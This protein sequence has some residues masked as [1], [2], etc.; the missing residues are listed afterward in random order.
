MD[1]KRRKV[2]LSSARAHFNSALPKRIADRFQPNGFRKALAG[3][4]KSH[5]G[6]TAFPYHPFWT[7]N[8]MLD[9]FGVGIGLY[10]RSLKAII[11]LLFVLAS[12]NILSVVKNAEYNPQMSLNVTSIRNPMLFYGSV[13][14]AKRESEH[15][16]DC[17]T[18]S[19]I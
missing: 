18:I 1:Q 12:V 17:N 13:L 6:D 5:D 15:Q 2:D 16:N 3:E 7:N 9:E 11:L 19:H 4:K 14:G 10:F 8:T